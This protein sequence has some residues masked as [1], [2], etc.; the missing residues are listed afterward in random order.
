[1]CELT[2]KV[3]NGLPSKPCARIRTSRPWKKLHGSYCQGEGVIRVAETQYVFGTKMSSNGTRKSPKQYLV[4][5]ARMC[6]KQLRTLSMTTVCSDRKALGWSMQEVVV[7]TPTWDD[8]GCACR[9][10]FTCHLPLTPL[11]T[12]KRTLALVKRT[13]PWRGQFS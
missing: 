4:Q 2:R 11:G 7:R 12:L 5:L 8:E 9:A 10:L 6:A 13:R 1:M 3:T